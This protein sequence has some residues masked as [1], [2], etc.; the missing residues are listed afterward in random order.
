MALIEEGESRARKIIIAN[1]SALEKLS[2]VLQEKE[3]INRDE[4]IAI[5]EDDVLRGA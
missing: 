1:K 3:V 4:M 2:D 5:F